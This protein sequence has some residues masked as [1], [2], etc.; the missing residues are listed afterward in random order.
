MAEFCNDL[1]IMCPNACS[2]K[3]Y[4]LGGKC[5][6]IPGYIGTDCSLKCDRKVMVNAAG[7]LT[8]VD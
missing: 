8:C 1:E 4:C 5:F 2:A 7:T 3:G 6:C